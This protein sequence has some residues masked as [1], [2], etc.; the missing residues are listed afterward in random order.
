LQVGA[1]FPD[2]RD[3]LD[4][5]PTRRHPNVHESESVRPALGCR[6]FHHAKPFLP[7]VSGIQFESLFVARRSRLAKDFGNVGEE[8]VIDLRCGQNFPKIGMN[9]RIIVDD[10]DPIILVTVVRVHCSWRTLRF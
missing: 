3:R 5:V 8:V 2:P 1:G 10:Q 6:S 9:R 4:T 7:L